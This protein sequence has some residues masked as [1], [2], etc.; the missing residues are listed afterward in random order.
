L[1]L[2]FQGFLKNLLEEERSASASLQSGALSDDEK[3]EAGNQLLSLRQHRFAEVKKWLEA[4][5]S[6]PVALSALQYIDMESEIN[7]AKKVVSTL[8]PR[9]RNNLRFKVLK[10]QIDQLGNPRLSNESGATG[11]IATGKKAPEIRLPNPK[12]DTLSLNNLLGKTVLIDFWASWCGPCRRENPNVVE[13][14]KKY[15]KDGFEVFSVS[16]D[17]SADLWQEAI[18]KDGL[19]WPNHVSDLGFWNSIAAQD[20]GVHSIP[21]PVLVGKDGNVIAF[22]DALRGKA[23]EARLQQIFGH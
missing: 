21:F 20:Y 1:L 9:F 16:L 4:H 7:L 18:K 5:Y 15:R 2:E 14:Y 12:G 19:I 10:N 17:K 8:E 11:K 3:M 13:A 23:L 6:S 22:G